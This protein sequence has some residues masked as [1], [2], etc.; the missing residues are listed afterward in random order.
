M[1]FDYIQEQ[2]DELTMDLLNSQ[3]CINATIIMFGQEVHS[4]SIYQGTADTLDGRITDSIQTSYPKD[5]PTFYRVK[6]FPSEKVFT[7][8]E[9]DRYQAGLGG[10]YEPFDRWI[11]CIESDVAIRDDETY[12]DRAQNV[13]IQGVSY[14]IKGLVKENFGKKPVIH[15]F[16]I[17]DTE[18]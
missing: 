2:Y 4:D 16:L 18:E 10:Q 17:K 11:S 9:G 13:S 15:V 12:F 6:V 3:F 7:R 8:H 14:K 5:M 1:R